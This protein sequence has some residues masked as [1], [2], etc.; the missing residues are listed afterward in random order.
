MS[1]PYV[2]PTLMAE[3]RQRL[4]L[5]AQGFGTLTCIRSH[6]FPDRTGVCDLTGAKEQEEIFVLS[7]RKGVTLKVS[8]SA[9]QIVAN[10]VEIQDADE[11]FQRLKEQKKAD[12][13]KKVLEE[14][15]LQERRSAPKG[16]LF[17]KRPTELLEKNK[18]S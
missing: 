4:T 17:K 10:V 12:R 14:K 5:F 11:W 9:M 1:L 16:M 15:A 6:Y 2:S 13:E 3:Y 7:N 8:R 18:N